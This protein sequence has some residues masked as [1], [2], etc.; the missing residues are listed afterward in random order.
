VQSIEKL[1]VNVLIDVA[2]SGA[3]EQS[4]QQ[5]FQAIDAS[6]ILY[7]FWSRRANRSSWFEQ[8][9]RYGMQ[10]NGAGFI[11]LVPLTDPRR[12]PPPIELVDQ[13]Q[14]SDRTLLYSEHEKSISAWT[15]IRSWFVG[16]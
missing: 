7:L 6:D 15:R 11:D 3:D 10:K 4:R 2:T 1:G 9:W 12:V 14:L 13:R 8:Q 16:Y 5:I